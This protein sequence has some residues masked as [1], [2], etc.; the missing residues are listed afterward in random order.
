M[1]RRAQSSATVR[2]QAMP[3]A[4]PANPPIVARTAEHASRSSGLVQPNRQQRVARAVVERTR[5]AGRRFA[6][7]GRDG[8]LVTALTARVEPFGVL[9]EFGDGILEGQRSGTQGLAQG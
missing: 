8:A 5:R 3:G 1:K 7:Q 9:F 6:P 4:S 2:G